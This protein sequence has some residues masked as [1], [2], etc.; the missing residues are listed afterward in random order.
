MIP[1]PGGTTASDFEPT[2][3]AMLAGLDHGHPLVNGYSGFFADR[4]DRLS[5]TVAAFPDGGSLDALEDAR[6]H[7]LVV[8]RRFVSSADIDQVEADPDWATAFEGEDR[9]VLRRVTDAP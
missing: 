3:E 2:V 4:Y 9:T 5:A 1:F 8:D 7:W 6:V